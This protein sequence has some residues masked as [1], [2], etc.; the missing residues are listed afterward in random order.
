MRRDHELRRVTKGIENRTKEAKVVSIKDCK[1]CDRERDCNN[2]INLGCGYKHFQPIKDPGNGVITYLKREY[3]KICKERKKPGARPPLDEPIKN[4]LTKE[5]GAR[6]IIKDFPV[7][8]ECKKRLV[9]II[10]IDDKSYEYRP[11]YD[12]AFQEEKYKK[13]IFCEVKG[14]GIESNGVLSAITAAQFV[15]NDARFEKERSKFYYIGGGWP[16]SSG[17]SEK[18]LTRE[19]FLSNRMVRPYVLW[20]ESKGYVT[21]YGVGDITDMLDD[22]KKYCS[23]E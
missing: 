5:D 21:F 11:K 23:Q 22:I 18:G 17:P 19:Y 6:Q 7:L 9:D 20:A 14:Y 10:Q 12:G 1:D 16:T 3:F 8:T 13:Y 2:K 15:K 4:L